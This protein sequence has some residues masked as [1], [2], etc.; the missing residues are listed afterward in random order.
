VLLAR[1]AKR[2]GAVQKKGE[3]RGFISFVRRR[4]PSTVV[5]IGTYRG[6]TLWL[7]SRLADRNAILVSID[8][9]GG[10]FGG[11]YDE[12]HV[13]VLKSFRGRHQRLELIRDDSHSPRTL[14][15]LKA[16][17]AGRPVDLLFIDGDHT[18][19]GVRKDYEMY[20]SLVG[21]GGVIAFH[22]I[23]PH[24]S[25]PTCEVDK[26]WNELKRQSHDTR[27]FVEI[28]PGEGAVWGGIGA[29]VVP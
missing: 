9:P 25:E 29:I 15:A 2:R 13:A 28:V 14:D 24:T 7:W 11:G 12:A 17:L 10:A 8:M 1:E 16:A 3:L 26:L 19:E 4:R 5:E 27:E 6:G 21:S 23:L 20:A 18:Y 22:D